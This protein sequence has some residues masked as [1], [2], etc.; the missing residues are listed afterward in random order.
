MSCNNIEKLYVHDT[1][2]IIANT[3]D[4]TRAY[5]WKSVKKFLDTIEKNSIIVEIG[6]GN[7]KNLQ[8]RDDCINLG[9]DLCDN[10]AK[11]SNKKGI[12]SVISNNLSI[13]L[14]DNIADYVLSI[15][16][17]HHL[18]TEARR[19]DALRELIRILKPGGKIIIQVWALEQPA[20]S[21]RK[22]FKQDNLIEFKNSMKTISEKRFYH[23][24]KKGELETIFRK[25]NNVNI[26]D[27][28]WEIGNWI[29]IAEKL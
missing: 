21:R 20:R 7:G 25:L 18:C 29:L 22:F 23:V 24:F 4:L 12:D 28:F 15:A 16:V 13:P 5:I 6:S 8:Y 17:I 19:I 11:I 27:V 26:I 2:Q 3:F 9:F 10:F 14:K 1:Y